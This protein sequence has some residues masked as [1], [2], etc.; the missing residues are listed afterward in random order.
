M[1]TETEQAWQELIVRDINHSEVEVWPDDLTTH[2]RV[3]VTPRREVHWDASFAELDGTPT[4]SVGLGP[5]PDGASEPKVGD[6]MWLKSHGFGS[7]NMGV[8]HGG[9]TWWEKDRADQERERAIWLA[10]HAR[11]QAQDF[12]RNRPAQ[13]A[14][15]AALLPEFQ[16]RIDR[17][18]REN[19]NFRA[20][21]EGYEMAPLSMA[22]ALV[23]WVKWPEFEIMLRTRDA[24]LP[25][26]EYASVKDY[27][28]KPDMGTPD[29]EA[30]PENLIR[31]L[32]ALNSALCGYRYQELDNIDEGM[33]LLTGKS[34]DPSVHSG[35]TW[36]YGIVFA[37]AY[38]N[39]QREF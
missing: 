20:G 28:W 32:D 27:Q 24:R 34:V 5:K 26:L 29:W 35:N 31:A 18:R 23:E 9:V 39:G 30:T 16:R 10:V 19:P 6:R 8:R 21:S 38:V 11:Q 33:K 12:V 36:G 37:V 4:F 2:E 3:G 17:F 13:D 25:K 1:T 22:T 15:Y 14:T 7:Q